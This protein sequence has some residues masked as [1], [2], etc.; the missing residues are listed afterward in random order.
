MRPLV[1]RV[2]AAVLLLTAATAYAQ[3]I[4]PPNPSRSTFIAL[5][6]VQELWEAENYAAAIPKLEALT[7]RVRDNNYEFA[8]A[9]QYLANT[10]VLS[11][12]N[13][14]ARVSVEAAL[15]KNE[16][17]LMIR[18]DFDIFYGQL[19]L[20]DE[21]YAVAVEHLE[22]WL[23]TVSAYPSKMAPPEP[24]QLFYVAYA[25]YMDK[26]LP[27][28]RELI[29]RTIDEAP[30][31]NDQW[32]R[33]YYQI[34]YEQQE[35]D[36]A[37][38]VLIGLLEWRPQREEYWRLLANHY[39]QQEQHR[40]GL[41]AMLLANLVDPATTQVDV[42]RIANLFALV[43]IPERGARHLQAHIDSGDIKADSAMMRQLGDLWLMARE[44]DKAKSALQAA[45]DQAP[46]GRTYR[47]LGGVHF[48]DEEWEA[49]YAAFLE[50]LDLG[51]LQQ[52]SQV[53]LLA[54]ISAYRAGMNSE[55]RV[56]LEAAAEDESLRGQA[57]ALLDR[58]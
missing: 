38:E 44:R 57:E 49:A 18:N 48:E 4:T 41:A 40:E 28:A 6:E 36:V 52:P 17:P 55:A 58:L 22:R 26:K 56:A 54:G 30:Q 33:V 9:H 12:D 11:G 32:E 7:E 3:Q 20:S 8:L 5:T 42:E 23:S 21:E 15:S 14:S 29:E 43:E 39:M 24:R 27:R 31:P 2:V 19:L 51:G 13:D 34:L 35:Y 45:A 16:L 10:H 37:L 46:D 47:L 1:L 25:N 53:R 50:A